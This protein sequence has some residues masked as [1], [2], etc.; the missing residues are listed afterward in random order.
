MKRA[1]SN[2]FATIRVDYTKPQEPFIPNLPAIPDP[3]PIKKSW[4]TD[5]E[6]LPKPTVSKFQKKR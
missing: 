2:H 4:T 6:V 5:R 1:H 3:V